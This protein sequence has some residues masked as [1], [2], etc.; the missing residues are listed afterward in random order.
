MLSIDPARIKAGEIADKL[1]KRRW[2]PIRIVS[3]DGKELVD[4][5]LQSRRCNLSCVFLRRLGKDDAPNPTY[6]SRA[7]EQESR[8]S[9]APSRI[10]SRIPGTESKYSVS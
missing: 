9:A 8:G 7:S 3:Q 1:F 2:I 6:Q 10:D 5:F 4:L